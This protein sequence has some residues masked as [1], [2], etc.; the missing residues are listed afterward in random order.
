[1]VAHLPRCSTVVPCAR[2]CHRAFADVWQRAAD[3]CDERAADLKSQTA[4]RYDASARSLK[5]L[6]IGQRVLLQDPKTGLW[7]RSGVIVGIGSQRDYLARL[8][9]GRTYWRNRRYLRPLWPMVTETPGS[10]RGAATD[11]GSIESGGSRL[12]SGPATT[13]SGIGTTSSGAGT[14]GD[15]RNGRPGGAVAVPEVPGPARRSRRLRQ[16]PKRLSVNWS[17]P[18]YEYV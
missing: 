5:H 12:Y 18:V 4:E 16:R 3:E 13:D 9:S 17:D 14:A 1:M 8:P 7:D 10:N 2:P 6:H 11:G 15:V